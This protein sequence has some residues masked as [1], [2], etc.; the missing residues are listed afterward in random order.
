MYYNARW[1]DTQFG[2]FAQTDTII[3]EKQ[4]GTQAWDRYAYANNN[5]INLSDST[6]HTA[7][8]DDKSNKD[9]D[10]NNSG[11]RPGDPNDGVGCDILHPNSSTCVD[12]LVTNGT[13]V[14]NEL[15]KQ[16]TLLWNVAVVVG[17]I[18]VVAAVVVLAPVAATVATGIVAAAAAPT[19]G[20]LV[21]TAIGAGGITAGGVAGAATAIA[22][23]AGGAA[24][25]LGAQADNLN[26]TASVFSA[27]DNGQM[28]VSIDTATGS[29]DIYGTGHVRDYP[30]SPFGIGSITSFLTP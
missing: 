3:P 14:S 20:G 5:P 16:S 27:N 15:S 28:Q 24:I 7:E 23:V 10:G 8:E 25:I 29:M 11:D 21:L 30:V 26:N 19:L 12:G 6:G 2:R 17:F 22:G 13:D 9:N 4:Q 1:Y 18:A